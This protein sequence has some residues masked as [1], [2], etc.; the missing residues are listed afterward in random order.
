MPK[1]LAVQG[2]D[3]PSMLPAPKG[4][5]ELAQQRA[6][7]PANRPN[8]GRNA[9]AAAPAETPAAAETPADASSGEGQTAWTLRCNARCSIFQNITVR[10]GNAVQ[11]LL[12]I[13]IQTQEQ[14]KDDFLLLSLPHGLHL[15]DGAEIQVDETKAEKIEIQTSDANG[16][17]AGTKFTPEMVKAF[18]AGKALKVTMI[19]ADRKK[20]TVPAP[21]SGFDE[22]YEKFQRLKK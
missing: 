8:T 4:A 5:F 6:P 10:R 12:T 22:A 19:S 7:A 11:R 21:L 3:T 14:S 1:A 13:T 18:N 9:P 16:A 15:P 2:G 20:I 17:Y